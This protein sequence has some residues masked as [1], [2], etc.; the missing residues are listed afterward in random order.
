MIKRFL[1]YFGSELELEKRFFR[2]SSFY[3]AVLAFL[4]FIQNVTTNL[5]IYLQLFS[6]VYVVFC[7]SCYFLSKIDKIFDIVKN[8]FFVGLI[9]LLDISYFLSGGLD[10]SI[11]YIF[12]ITFLM[13]NLSIKNRK[14]SQFIVFVVFIINLFILFFLEQK[15]PSLLIP[16]PNI[17]AKHTDLISGFFLVSLII[18]LTNNFFKTTYE[19]LLFSIDSKNKELIISE[20]KAYIE[21]EKAEDANNAKKEFLSVMSH[22]IRTPLNAIISIIQLLEKNEV[23]KEDTLIKTLKD[24]S[25][26]L[27]ALVS[28]ILDFSKIESGEV[29]LEEINFNL[30]D[31]IESIVN[32]HKAQAIEKKNTL[33]VNFEGF[34]SYFFLGDPLRLGQIFINLIS[35]AIKFTENGFIDFNIKL[36]EKNDNKSKIYFEIKDNGIGISQDKIESVFLRSLLKRI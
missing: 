3:T 25:E 26:N 13:L 31:I 32:V 14:V 19:K 30:K 11:T 35:N 1:P 20:K 10:S 18:A 2:Y 29:Q 9:I 23:Y 33:N 34:E 5:S 8:I 15:Y 24:S 17:E 27:L 7:I 21:K 6:L 22:E 36:I 4:S 28:N 12:I 16:Y